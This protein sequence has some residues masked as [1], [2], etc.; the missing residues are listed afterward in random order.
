MKKRIVR[1][2]ILSLLAAFIF[3]SFSTKDAIGAQGLLGSAFLTDNLED[4]NYTVSETA[5]L[6]LL[7]EGVSSYPELGSSYLAFKEAVGF[8][9]SGGDYKV[10]ND[11]GYMGKYQFGRGTLEM[12]GIRDVNRFLNDPQLQ[13]AAFYANTSRNKW[14]LIRDIERFSGQ[15][16]NGVKITESGILAAA[17]LAGPGNVKKYLRSWGASDFNDGFGTSIRSYFKNFAGYDTSF[18]EPERRPKV[19]IPSVL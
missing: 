18:V 5:D 8:K 12:I 13:E 9:E 10:V 14:I 11:F 7:D 6:A 16:I 4:L 15:V 17:H 19:N 3:Y 2:S 1:F